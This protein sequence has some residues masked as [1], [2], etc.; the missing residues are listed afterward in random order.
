MP[1][2]DPDI[3]DF[4]DFDELVASA[5]DEPGAYVDDND[6]DGTDDTV[7]VDVDDDGVE[8]V[9]FLDTDQDGTTD[10]VLAGGDDSQY[11]EMYEDTDQDGQLDTLSVDEDLD[12]SID[13]TYTYDT[14]S[15]EWVEDGSGADT[16]DADASIF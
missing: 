4:S 12:G 11:G 8:D 13:T 1:D 14:S 3:S 2:T 16:S 10:T 5:A 15:E 7:A 6:G 9:A